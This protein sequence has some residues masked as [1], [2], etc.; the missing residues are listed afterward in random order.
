MLLLS[1]ATSVEL[2]LVTVVLL[3]GRLFRLKFLLGGE[4]H[5]YLS[6]KMKAWTSL[7]P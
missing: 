1:K 6:K 3:H 5:L 2:L 4:N 7:T